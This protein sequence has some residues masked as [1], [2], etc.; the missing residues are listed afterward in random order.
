MKKQ[1]RKSIKVLDSCK[2]CPCYTNLYWGDPKRQ[3]GCNHYI[4]KKIYKRILEYYPETDAKMFGNTTLSGEAPAIAF[5]DNDIKKIETI[6][7]PYWC[8]LERSK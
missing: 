6:G 2:Q 5:S 3:W 4:V 8:P 1:F 7:F